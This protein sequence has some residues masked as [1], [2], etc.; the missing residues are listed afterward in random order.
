V[1]KR[2]FDVL[3]SSIGLVVFSPVLLP[4]ALAIWLQDFHSP[5]YIAKR[6]GKNGKPFDMI[7]FRSMSIGA[8]KTGV[9]STSDQDNRITPIGHIVRRLKLDEI[10]QL[11]NVLI[12]DMSV[13]GPR[14]QVSR[15]GTEL[16][17]SV[18]QSLLEVKPGISDLASIVFADE[19][20]ILKSSKNPDLDY[21]RLI[22][23]WKSRLA[24]LYTK[25]ISLAL[26]LKIIG[27][28]VLTLV[29]RK[30][31]LAGVYQIARHLGAEPKTLETILRKK[32]LEPYPPPG[33][34]QIVEELL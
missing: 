2:F 30:K 18:E 15:H 34:D 7:K 5:F 22:R 11:W 16:Y 26:D 4:T 12:G 6:V 3:A 19:G 27:L 21:N 32:E 29:D 14:P 31:S 28:T 33:T 1:S 20:Q 10:T 13:V 23:P 17:T 8:N 24:L 25:N 9:N